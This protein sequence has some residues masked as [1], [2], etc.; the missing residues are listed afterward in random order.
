MVSPIFIHTPKLTWA[1]FPYVE[2]QPATQL[3]F[4]QRLGPANGASI[5]TL[6]TLFECPVKLLRAPRHCCGVGSLSIHGDAFEKTFTCQNGYILWL[7]LQPQTARI[8]LTWLH[9]K[10]WKV[11]DPY[12]RMGQWAFQKYMVKRNEPTS[13]VPR[14]KWSQVLFQFPVL[15]CSP[16][17]GLQCR[18]GQSRPALQAED[19]AHSAWVHDMTWSHGSKSQSS[20]HFWAA[21]LVILGIPWYSTTIILFWGAIILRCLTFAHMICDELCIVEG[22]ILP[23]PMISF[24]KI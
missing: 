3:L 22:T 18:H 8:N 1:W 12:F 4:W 11:Q 24:F 7:S 6:Q 2:Q 9:T 14:V 23:H 15:R 13:L 20:Y 5:L 19:L 17:W 10:H 21:K 16:A